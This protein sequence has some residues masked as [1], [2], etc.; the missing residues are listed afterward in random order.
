MVTGEHHGRV[1]VWEPRFDRGR[2]EPLWSYKEDGRVAQRLLCC[3]DRG[4]LVISPQHGRIIVLHAET[5]E[6]V[7]TFAPPSPPTAVAAYPKAPVV[8]VGGRD[9]SLT[10]WDIHTGRHLGG[11][12]AHTDR[13]RALAVSDAGLVLSGSRDGTATL[14]RMHDRSPID[15]FRP[16]PPSQPDVP[17]GRENPWELVVAEGTAD[18][19]TWM[20]GGVGGQVHFLRLT[21]D[22][23]LKPR[24]TGEPT[25]TEGQVDVETLLDDMSTGHADERHGTRATRPLATCGVLDHLDWH[26]RKEVVEDLKHLIVHGGTRSVREAA[27]IALAEI[28]R[29]ATTTQLYRM[30]KLHMDGTAGSLLTHF[31]GRDAPTIETLVAELRAAGNFLG[32]LTSHALAE[33]GAAA[34]PALDAALRALLVPDDADSEWSRDE[35]TRFHLMTALRAIGAP[36]A[37]ATETLLAVFDDDEAYRGTYHQAKVALCAIGLPST[38]EA[39]I[40]EA[41][42]CFDDPDLDCYWALQIL[43]GMPPE[44][45]LAAR[46]LTELLSDILK[47]DDEMDRETAELITERMASHTMDA[48]LR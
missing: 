21:H 45:L 42:A 7:S 38:V 39:V 29:D 37:P 30:F 18:G 13:I 14:W 25:V 28:D 6:T 44:S 9:G 8:V 5:G 43:L 20:I 11:V 48:A 10:W 3:G 27:V 32:V 36:A 4:R 41:R 40:A 16:A 34:V 47:C 12:A 17:Y 1:S 26:T 24:R 19:R 15:R 31:T 35:S 2:Q 46:G 23:R 33:R 22:F